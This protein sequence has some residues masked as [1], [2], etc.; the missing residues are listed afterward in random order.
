MDT[1]LDPPVTLVVSMRNSAT[2]IAECLQG[3]AAQDYPIAE[4]LLFDN[5]STDT[6]VAQAKAFLATSPVP[7]RLIEQTVNGG[8]ALSYNTGAERA[9]TEWVVFV[10]SDSVLPTPH[11][12]GRLVRAARAVPGGVGASPIIT[13]PLDVW[14][15][16]P[17][18]QKLLFAKVAGKAY[19]CMCG[20]FD[21]IR[22]ETFLKIGGLDR[23]RFTSTCGYG[24]EDADLNWRLSKQGS[25]ANSSAKVIHLHDFSGRYPL[26][27]LFATRK[28]LARTYG[29]ILQFQGLRPLRHKLPFFAKPLLALL[30]LPPLW[31]LFSLVNSWRMYSQRSA[32]LNW[33]ILLVPWIDAALIYYEA[34]WFVEGLFAPPA[35]AQRRA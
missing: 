13:I 32:A 31:L 1:R 34:F 15:R 8:L 5:V 25:V 33:R 4:I 14:A 22:R 35:D 9:A 10:H 28:L 16:F 27:S 23:K 20:K 11:E 26:S 3:L 7:I 2:T 21:C 19:A 30:P 18:W 17:F 12:L 29:K 24:G 6:S